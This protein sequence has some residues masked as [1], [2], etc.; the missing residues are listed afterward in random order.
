MRTA[1]KPRRVAGVIAVRDLVVFRAPDVHPVILAPVGGDRLSPC[2]QHAYEVGQVEFLVHRYEIDD[3]AG[4]HVDAHPDGELETRFLLVTAEVA[5]RADFN[6]PVVN[7]DRS[8]MDG[9][10]RDTTRRV[11]P[12]HQLTEREGGQDI[13]VD[14]EAGI[15]EP[16]D[17]PKRSNCPE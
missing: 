4:E 15:A 12:F 7:R 11:M 14:Q 10:S 16:L 2:D 1:K 5:V 6:H 17:L 8:S 3:P 9:E 13:A